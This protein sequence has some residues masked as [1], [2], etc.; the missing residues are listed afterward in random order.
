VRGRGVA[1]ERGDAAWDSENRC[2]FVPDTIISLTGPSAPRRLPDRVL[3]GS[4]PDE[5]P[6]GRALDAGLRL[7]PLAVRA[8]GQ[9]AR[10]RDRSRARFSTP[11]A[12]RR[13][14][15]RGFG[16]RRAAWV[17]RRMDAAR[18]SHLPGSS[19]ASRTR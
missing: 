11:R 6:Y 15:L 3:Q 7:R 4:Q 14:R 1:E 13:R 9:P 17:R 16:L 18:R 2:G 8:D 19:A 5:A 12:A 10:A